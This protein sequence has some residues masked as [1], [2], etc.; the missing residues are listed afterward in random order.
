MFAA[1]GG[2]LMQSRA[3][4]HQPL[5]A[6]SGAPTGRGEPT[7]PRGHPM[8]GTLFSVALGAASFACALTLTPGTATALA[9]PHAGA[10]FTVNSTGDRPDAARNGVCATSVKTECTLRA[11]LQEANASG[12]ATI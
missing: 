7:N 11:A 1:P 3:A 9:I 4:Q 2:G 5:Q 10:V 6:G 8:R 12:N